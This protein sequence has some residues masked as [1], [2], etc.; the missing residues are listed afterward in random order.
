MAAPDEDAARDGAWLFAQ[1]CRFVAGAATLEPLPPPGLPEVA[2]AGRSNVG[3]SSLINALTGRK[4]W[5][6]S[7][8]RR[9]ARSRSISSISASRLMLVDLPGYGFASARRPRSRP[10]PRWLDAYLARPAE[11]APR[12]AADRRRHGLKDDDRELM[13]L[14]DRRPSP[15]RSC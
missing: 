5:R 7:P 14:L 9:A 4:T 3:K 2:F 13:D 12:P 8:T 11:P 6:A 1:E 15:T 10:G